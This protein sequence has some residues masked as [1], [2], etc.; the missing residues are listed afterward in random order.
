M[1]HTIKVIKYNSKTKNSELWGD[2]WLLIK[3]ETTHSIR[4]L[5]Q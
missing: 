2:T 4:G 1:L 3:K 5:L